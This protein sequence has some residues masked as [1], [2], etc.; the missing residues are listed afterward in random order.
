MSY[1][2]RER[3]KI[4]LREKDKQSLRE[5]L[6]LSEK[7]IEF[8]LDNIRR[9]CSISDEILVALKEN[10]FRFKDMDIDE[11]VEKLSKQ[12]FE[13]LVAEWLER[14]LKKL[15]YKKQADKKEV[16]EEPEEESE[17]DSDSDSETEEVEAET[18]E[19]ECT[20]K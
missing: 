13:D 2:F 3:L 10:D 17:S 15:G 8:L 11:I 20:E 19:V 16:E 6:G 1:S 9:V 7:D 5:K 14:A 12:E 4:A 18:E